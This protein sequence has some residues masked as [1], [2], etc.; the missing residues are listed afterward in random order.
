[1]N[2]PARR[3]RRGERAI[4]RSVGRVLAVVA[5]F[6]PLLAVRS[7]RV[8]GAAAVPAEQIVAAA[9]VEDGR[10]LLRVDIDA[11]A[12]RVAAIPKVAQARVQ[13]SYPSTIR[14]VVVERVPVAYV[15]SPQ[16]PHLLDAGG[17]EF[18]IEPAPPNLPQ[19]TVPDPGPND[20]K[21]TA[22][23]AV[24]AAVPPVL[25]DQIRAVTVPSLSAITFALRDNRV[26]V[27]GDDQ[28]SPRKVE[29]ALP[30][31]AQPGQT[32]DVS[33]PDLPTVR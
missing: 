10:P 8:E 30:L 14:I 1:M 19:L 4:A 11:A 27:W 24:L 2:R 25:R 23:L 12:R 17:V 15:D 29:V 13:R 26:L 9:A 6:S 18:A 3:E 33:S 7:V 5:W 28:H 21:T 20:P 32:Y 31:L 22:A 16:G